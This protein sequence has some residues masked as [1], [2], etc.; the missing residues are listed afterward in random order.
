M[1]FIEVYDEH[2]AKV[3]AFTKFKTNNEVGEEIA[4]DVFVRVNKHLPNYDENKS[5]M[6]TWVITIA[7]RMVIDYW[8][9]QKNELDK[10]SV[11]GIVNDAG[12]ETI[13][14][15]YMEN[16]PIEQMMATERRQA[17]KECINDLDGKYFVIADLY[18]NM[19][20]SYDE[21]VK[22]LKLN[23]NTVKGQLLRARIMIGEMITK[24]G[25]Q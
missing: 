21:C 22:A 17:F 13:Q 5:K 4:Q 7:N 25:L 20:F 1:E 6:G 18:F 10:I 14:L 9:K 3:L 11:S 16:N 12:E 24:R 23:L 19:D 15:T 8:R 2:Y